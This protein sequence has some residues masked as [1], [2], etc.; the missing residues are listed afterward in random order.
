VWQGWPSAGFARK[1]W[2]IYHMVL[3]PRR[4][5]LRS[6]F[7]DGW[8]CA[9]GPETLHITTNNALE[10]KCEKRELSIIG[11]KS[12]TFSLKNTTHS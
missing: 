2:I 10:K 11:K 4:S 6:V 7:S 5:A 3:S 12:R 1:T 8:S 9:V